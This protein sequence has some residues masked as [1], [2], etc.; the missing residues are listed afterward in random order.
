MQHMAIHKTCTSGSACHSHLSEM[1]PKRSKCIQQ[2]A[3]VKLGAAQ[4]SLNPASCYFPPLCGEFI[5][6]RFAIGLSQSVYVLRVRTPRRKMHCGQGL[7]ALQGP[8]GQMHLS[9]YLS[10]SKAPPGLAL[11]ICRGFEAGNTEIVLVKTTW[12][13]CPIRH[14]VGFGRTG[15][16]DGDT[17][18]VHLPY[19]ERATWLGLTCTSAEDEA[20]P[21]KSPV[22]YINVSES[23]PS[24]ISEVGHCPMSFDFSAEVC[25]AQISCHVLLRTG[26]AITGR[27]RQMSASRSLLGGRTGHFLKNKN[28]LRAIHSRCGFT[29]GNILGCPFPIWCSRPTVRQRLHFFSPSAAANRNASSRLPYFGFGWIEWS[30]EIS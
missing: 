2:L 14:S 3:G 30:M 4:R 13:M 6:R 7:A 24:L 16:G 23:H 12:I 15:M 10:E 9:K 28:T 25:L 19:L 17:D 5:F 29:N 26:Y 11:P 18:H 20:T 1:E 21:T 8:K 22:V 27:L